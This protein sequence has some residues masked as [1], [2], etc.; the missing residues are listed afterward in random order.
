M[1]SALAAVRKAAN[2]SRAGRLFHSEKATKLRRTVRNA[3]TKSFAA[4]AKSQFHGWQLPEQRHTEIMNGASSFRGA[5]AGPW[6][7]PF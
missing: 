3:A 5:M 7:E 2:V 4:S 6:P 1:A